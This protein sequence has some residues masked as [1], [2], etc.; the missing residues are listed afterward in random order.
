MKLIWSSYSWDEY[1]YGQKVD[2]KILKRITELIKSCQPTPFEG[3]GKSEVLKGDLNGYWSGRINS[4]HRLMYKYE[5]DK[6]FIASCG[7]HYGK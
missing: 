2:K 4:E 1:L 3:I 6:L 7:Y 5:E